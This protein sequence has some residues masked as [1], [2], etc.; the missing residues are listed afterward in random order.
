MS[1]SQIHIFSDS[2]SFLAITC[3]LYNPVSNRG[4]NIKQKAEY[5]Q[6]NWR[7]GFILQLVVVAY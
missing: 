6:Y 7:F 5:A 4:I 2:K 3:V 1:I